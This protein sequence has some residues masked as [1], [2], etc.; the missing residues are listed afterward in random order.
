LRRRSVEDNVCGA[1]AA[2]IEATGPSLVEG[3]AVSSSSFSAAAAMEALSTLIS[4][5]RVETEKEMREIECSLKDEKESEENQSP[6]RQ[7]LTTDH[8]DAEKA[9]QEESNLASSRASRLQK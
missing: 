5:S 8:G 9:M 4:L 7:H 6:H 1:E 2:T 3:T